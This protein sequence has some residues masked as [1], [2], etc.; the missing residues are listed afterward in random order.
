[1]K[2]MMEIWHTKPLQVVIK[3]FS[4]T[5]S[6]NE[7]LPRSVQATYMCPRPMPA[8]PVTDDTLPNLHSQSPWHPCITQRRF[9]SPRDNKSRVKKKLLSRKR[10]EHVVVIFAQRSKTPHAMQH[11]K[12]DVMDEIIF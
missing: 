7:N 9:T 3:T 6:D 12:W 11:A 10:G 8:G 2:K 4:C 1:M 5:G